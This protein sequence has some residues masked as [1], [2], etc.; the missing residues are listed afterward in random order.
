MSCKQNTNT[1]SIRSDAAIRRQHDT[2]VAAEQKKNPQ[3]HLSLYSSDLGELG[4]NM[5]DV[6]LSERVCLGRMGLPIEAAANDDV[7]PAAPFLGAAASLSND[8]EAANTCAAAKS[9]AV[10]RCE[11]AGTAKLKSPPLFCAPPRTG[12]ASGLRRD[13]NAASIANTS[14]DVT[15]AAW[16]AC[17]PAAAAEASVFKISGIS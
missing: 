12:E 3:S 6:S 9:V 8:S 5:S 1:H 2:R 7:A 15:V 10:R 11:R 13:A 4:E 17:G 16:R 14:F